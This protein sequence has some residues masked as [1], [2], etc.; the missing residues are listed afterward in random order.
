MDLSFLN[1]DSKILPILIRMYD[2][3]KK[4]STTS[5]TPENY[6]HFTESV[7]ELL[8]LDMDAKEKELIADILIELF[9]Q[10][11]ADLRAAI[12]ERLSTYDDIP[13]RLILHVAND[14]I[15]VAAP[16]LK[17]SIMLDE[18]DLD[19]IISNKS[20]MYWRAIAQRRSLSERVIDLLS[21]TRDIE[22]AI[23]LLDNNNITLTQHSLVV[24]SD[25]ARGHDKVA[26]SLVH[27]AEVTSEIAS[28]LYE[29]VGQMVKQSILER[30]SNEPA[31]SAVSAVD[32][33]VLEFRE[34][35]DAKEA[36]DPS[37]SMLKAA[38]R[39]RDK[40][41]LNVEL[42]LGT[43]RRGQLPAFI[44]QFARFT[45][46]DT[47]TARNLLS[48]PSGKGLATVC[49][50]LD[51]ERNDFVS[52]F[53]LTSRLHAKGKAIDNA[54]ILSAVNHYT[55]VDKDKAYSAFSAI[56]EKYKS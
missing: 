53:L 15:R 12:S 29:Y 6:S 8:A 37:D 14:E 47:K 45:G 10:A 33:I 19:T 24:L 2:A 40:G 54:S 5:S 56:P 48:Q 16:V 13:H 26:Y 44:A 7:T 23:E 51:V 35:L 38:D 28:Y 31:F 17:N 11:E 36:K 30:F 3:N 27:R 9:R 49:K 34:D 4:F 21:D 32:D 20:S 1:K 25:V 55:A 22:T 42:M 41:L 52:I 18:S 46:F 50:A 43:L 39:Y